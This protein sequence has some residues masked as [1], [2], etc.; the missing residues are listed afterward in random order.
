V[1]WVLEALGVVQ[2]RVEVEVF[3]SVEMA[4]VV[5]AVDVVEMKYGIAAVVVGRVCWTVVGWEER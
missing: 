3:Q 4:E 2:V 1:V 5:V